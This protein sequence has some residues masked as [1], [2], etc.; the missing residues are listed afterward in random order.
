M[1]HHR[2]VKPTGP[3]I[4][5]T[6]AVECPHCGSQVEYEPVEDDAGSFVC[7][8]EWPVCE[9]CETVIDV[10]PLSLVPVASAYFSARL[11]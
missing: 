8:E 4:A 6:L 5:L 9:P 3:V 7:V 10:P 2:I 11:K 1:T